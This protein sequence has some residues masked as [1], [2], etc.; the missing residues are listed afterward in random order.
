M[1]DEFRTEQCTACE[2]SDAPIAHNDMHVWL[3]ISVPLMRPLEAKRALLPLLYELQK[4]GSDRETIIGSDMDSVKDDAVA[5]K[6]R[7]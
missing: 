2:N 1:A 4:A 5:R 3:R 6:H 7:L